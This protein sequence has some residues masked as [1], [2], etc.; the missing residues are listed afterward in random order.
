VTNAYLI[1]AWIA[2]ALLSLI[3]SVNG[4]S[5]TLSWDLVLHSPIGMESAHRSTTAWAPIYFVEWGLI[6]CVLLTVTH[7][8]LQR[9]RDRPRWLRLPSLV[10]VPRNW[11]SRFTRMTH[12]GLIALVVLGTLYA[13]GH[14]LRKT[15]TGT[16]YCD[17]GTLPITRWGYFLWEPAAGH[18]YHDGAEKGVEFFP[19]WEVWAFTVVYLGVLVTWGW[20]VWR[21]GFRPSEPKAATDA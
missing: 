14:F 20:C 3:E 21:L 7:E 18:C 9:F 5:K 19:R 17:G 15:F 13:G 10:G 4:M 11:S 12:V 2:V 8:V 1:T 6:Q 16:V